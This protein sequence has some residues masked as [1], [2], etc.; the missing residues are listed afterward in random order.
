MK[1]HMKVHHIGVATPDIREAV[2]YFERILNFIP[3]S[4]ITYDVVQKVRVMFLRNPESG[5]RIEL[6]EPAADDS[7][8]SNI[9]KKCNSLAHIC[10]EVADIDEAVRE[11]VSSGAIV[12]QEPVMAL[13]FAN[14]RI[15]FL[16][17][18]VKLVVELLQAEVST[19][20]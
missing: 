6:I 7:P 10:Y 18:P 20:E 12:L 16:Y 15:A 8:V 5:E 4:S 1:V 3:E 11:L 9:L 17:T 14:R 2:P 13:A 19:D